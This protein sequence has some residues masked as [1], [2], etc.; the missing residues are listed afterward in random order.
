LYFVSNPT[1]EKAPQSKLTYLY[2]FA[3]S[4]FKK[5]KKKK[6]KKE[7]KKRRKEE[8][9]KRRKEE[10]K[11]KRK[12]EKTQAVEFCPRLAQCI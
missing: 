5:E 12:K 11:K 10:K 6:R 4:Q 8:K 2:D 3:H 7:K 9:K 1:F